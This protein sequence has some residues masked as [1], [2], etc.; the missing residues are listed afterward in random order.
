LNDI[1]QV[2]SK[3]RIVVMLDTFEQLSALD[4]WTCGLAQRLHPNAPLVIAGRVMPNWDHQWAGWLVQTQV[5][6]LKPMTE[7]DMRTLARRYY[8]TICGGEPD[9][10]QVETI[11]KFA[12]G[13]PM[14]VTTAVQL[15]VKYGVEDFQA[16]KPEIIADLVDRLMEGVP[17]EMVPALEA[18]A[19]VRW[20]DQPILRA[21]MAQEDVR[22]VYNE[23]RRF[24]FV[25]SRAEV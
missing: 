25:R 4:E 14:V 17:K 13:L 12:H 20:F 2:A 5:E 10:K 16:V 1:A 23:L 3:R 11:I 9:P 19:I 7:E 18:A 15:W 22:E 21:V 6:E 8:A 24:P